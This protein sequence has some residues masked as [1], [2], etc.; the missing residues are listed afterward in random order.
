LGIAIGLGIPFIP[1]MP[2]GHE[3]QAQR[4]P[5]RAAQAH[6]VFASEVRH[7]VEVGAAEQQH[8]VQWLSKR[9][10]TPLRVP[11]LATEGYEL[12]GGRLLSGPDGP[13]AQFMYQDGGGKRLTLYVT[14]KTQKESTTAFRFAQEGPVSV[15]YWIDADCCYAITAELGKGDL[16][17]IATTVYQQLET[18]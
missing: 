7:P 1:G 14:G 10:G 13:V 17:R 8:L 5:V 3:V 2:L 9:L 16:A 11:V 18:H 15:F 6:V 12:L 4:L